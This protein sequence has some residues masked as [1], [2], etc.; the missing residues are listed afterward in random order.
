MPVVRDVVEYERL[1]AHGSIEICAQA[2]SLYMLHTHAPLASGVIVP[3]AVTPHVQHPVPTRV[4]GEPCQLRQDPPLDRNR[5]H[6]GILHVEPL[7]RD[8]AC[9]AREG[10]LTHRIP[11]LP[12]HGIV[13]VVRIL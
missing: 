11:C 4:R 12:R 5:Q 7:V 9:E 3:L 6:G 13:D 8:H 1:P 10:L 2:V